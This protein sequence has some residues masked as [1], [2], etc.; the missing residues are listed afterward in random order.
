M[1]VVGSHISRQNYFYRIDKFRED[2]LNQAEVQVEDFQYG[3]YDL[4]FDLDL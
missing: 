2:I 1:N 3:G 4:H